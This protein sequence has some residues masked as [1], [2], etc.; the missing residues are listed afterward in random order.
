MNEVDEKSQQWRD[1]LQENG[2]RLTDSRLAV[3]EVIAHTDRVL[4]PMEVYEI[5]HEQNARL[6]LVTVY[7]TIEKLEELGLITRVHQHAGCQAF[8]P[9]RDGH[10]HLL[11]CLQCGR[12]EYFEGENLEEF[13]SAVSH[14]SGYQI[15]EHWMQLFGICSECRLKQGTD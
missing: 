4:K 3:I 1:I 9:A 12:F 15:Q 8:V 7:R 2:Y 10:H 13:F 11:L 6:G 14:D 5:A